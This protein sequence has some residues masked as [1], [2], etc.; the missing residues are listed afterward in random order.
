VL[1]AIGRLPRKQAI[2]VLMRLVQD[3]PFDAIARVL[4]CSE[5]TVRIHVS[6]GRTRLRKWLSHLC[7]CSS[8]EVG[9]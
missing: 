8:Q 4:D 7:T 6:K 5:V 3:E 2:A 9:K 1:R